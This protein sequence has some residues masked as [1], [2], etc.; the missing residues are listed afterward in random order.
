MV[1]MV[2]L[3]GKLGLLILI[4]LLHLPRQPK[5]DGSDFAV[6]EIFMSGHV[7]TVDSELHDS[8]QAILLLGK[9]A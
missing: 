9:A 1:F 4:W 8:R 7:A 6:G 3:L 2:C 5:G